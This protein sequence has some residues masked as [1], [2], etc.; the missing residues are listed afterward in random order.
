MGAVV[1]V[2]YVLTTLLVLPPDALPAATKLVETV[3]DRIAD[4]AEARTRLAYAADQR[5]C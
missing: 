1:A 4:E 3:I 5:L 2:D